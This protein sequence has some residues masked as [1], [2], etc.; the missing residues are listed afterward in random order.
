MDIKAYEI[1]DHEGDTIYVVPITDDSYG[2]TFWYVAAGSV[3]VNQTTTELKD[4]CD[5]NQIEDVDCRTACNPLC[6]LEQLKTLIYD[7]YGV[8]ECWTCSD[9]DNTQ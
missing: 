4:G 9:F 2:D 7:L 6:S 3:A 1:K 8:E 5:I